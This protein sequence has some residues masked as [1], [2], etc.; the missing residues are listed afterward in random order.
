[1]AD[2]EVWRKQAHFEEFE[3]SVAPRQPRFEPTGLLF[4]GSSQIAVEEN[5]TTQNDLGQ[6][7]YS[8]SAHGAPPGT[9]KQGTEIGT[10]ASVRRTSSYY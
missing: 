7:T 1:M 5:A 2:W 8:K 3:L 6:L 10:C 4:L 9:P